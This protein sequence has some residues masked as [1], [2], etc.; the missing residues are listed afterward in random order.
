MA[1]ATTGP[2]VRPPRALIARQSVTRLSSRRLTA[3]REA[4][5]AAAAI[6]DER[7][8]N[9]HA[10]IHGLPLPISCQH[11]SLLFLPWHRA[12]L[13]F[14][15]LALRDRVAD[16]SLP[17]WDWASAAARRDGI[18]AAYARQRVDDQPNP[19]F[20]MPVPQTAQVNGQ[21]QA[22]F[23][24]PSPPDQLPTRSEVL[25]ILAAPNFLDFNERLET[26]HNRLHVWIGGTTAMVPWAAYDPVFWAH[27]AM[28][29][30]LWRLWQLRNPEGNLNARFLRQALPPFP[31][32]VGDTLDV[33][34][35]GYDYAGSTVSRPGG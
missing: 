28:V 22:T 19:L 14:F 35:L 9:Y 30:R 16:V 25:S 7:G 6:Q 12:Y 13:Y 26:L 33:T 11:G 24:N 3:L 23:R 15:E 32:T 2:V 34:A 17:W 21:P 20:S 8:F 5:R 31:M 1:V 4:F 27:H 18:P 29:D 10:G